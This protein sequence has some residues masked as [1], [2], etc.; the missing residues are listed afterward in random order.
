[1]DS[2]QEG[3]VSLQGGSVVSIVN[4]RLIYRSDSSGSPGHLFNTISTPKGRQY[5]LVLP[6]ST[7]VWLNAASSITFPTEF[8]DSQRKVRMAGEIF[9]DVAANPLKKF[10]VVSGD[11][12]TEVLGTQFNVSSY[13]DD[14]ESTITLQEGRVNTQK[15]D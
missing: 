10:I 5:Q 1:L 11:V 9:F 3:I 7:K 8:N 4:G 14:E 2:L 12:H 13:S 6:D 15:G